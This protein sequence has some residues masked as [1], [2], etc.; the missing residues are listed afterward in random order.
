VIS[1]WIPSNI[2]ISIA[3]NVSRCTTDPDTGTSKRFALG[4]PE[5]IGILR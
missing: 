4:L 1:F 2:A 3:L 5:H